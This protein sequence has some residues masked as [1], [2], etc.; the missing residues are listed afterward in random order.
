[1]DLQTWLNDAILTYKNYKYWL[2]EHQNECLTFFQED[3]V[4]IQMDFLGF[5]IANKQDTLAYWTYI[6]GL[7]TVY[8]YD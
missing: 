8:P 6:E 3:Y 2:E 7:N 4:G 1:M 5:D